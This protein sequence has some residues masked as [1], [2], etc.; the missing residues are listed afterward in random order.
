MAS[1][2]ADPIIDLVGMFTSDLLAPNDNAADGS[3]STVWNLPRDMKTDVAVV[4][5]TAVQQFGLNVLVIKNGIF[6]QAKLHD[7]AGNQ[8]PVITVARTS[9]SAERMALGEVDGSYK[10]NDPRLIEKNAAGTSTLLGPKGSATVFNQA[11]VVTVDVTIYDLNEM[12]ADQVYLFVKTVM[13]AAEEAFK[14]LGYIKPPIRTSGTD[15]GSILDGDGGQKFLF[16]RTLTYQGEHLDYIGAID[17][18]ARLIAVQQ[19]TE[20]VLDPNGSATT[21]VTLS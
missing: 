3:V 6:E 21:T 19:N 17:T 20:T 7:D 1:N 12:R 9:D 10:K 14:N 18:L 16:E 2:P 15:G 5:L 11:S 13:F 8:R 4:L